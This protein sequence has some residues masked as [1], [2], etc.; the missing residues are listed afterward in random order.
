MGRRWLQQVLKTSKESANSAFRTA[1]GSGGKVFER[2]RISIQVPTSSAI[3]ATSYCIW[4]HRGIAP[5]TLPT[6]FIVV[7]HGSCRR[8]G[9]KNGMNLRYEYLWSIDS[10]TSGGKHIHQ[11]RLQRVWLQL[12]RS[13]VFQ[14]WV[15][16]DVSCTDPCNIHFCESPHSSAWHEMI[17]G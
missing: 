3:K 5:F 2:A 9:I 16:S 7:E 15:A 11:L 8:V 1:S 10:G 4:R 12:L 14:I 13:L 6:A 17:A